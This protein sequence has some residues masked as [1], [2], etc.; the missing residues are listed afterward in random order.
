MQ[1]LSLFIQNHAILSALFVTLL[2][3][4]FI[5]E[6][7][8]LKRATNTVSPHQLTQFKEKSKKLEKMM[9]SLPLILICA[10]GLESPK[11]APMLENQGWNVHCGWI[12]NR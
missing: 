10:K 7:V 8:R 1:E 6:F 4:L 5:L 11:I 2:V 3:L 9:K 12:H